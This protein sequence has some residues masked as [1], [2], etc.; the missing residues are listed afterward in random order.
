MCSWDWSS[1]PCAPDPLDALSSCTIVSTVICVQIVLHVQCL[2]GVVKC[3][4]TSLDLSLTWLQWS[5]NCH[6]IRIKF[7][8]DHKAPATKIITVM[9]Y[10]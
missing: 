5:L 3:I 6:L 8:F 9:M 10:V 2:F 1:D 4:G 7:K